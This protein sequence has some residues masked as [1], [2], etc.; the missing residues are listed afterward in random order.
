MTPLQPLAQSSPS[1]SG[2]TVEL[3]TLSLVLMAIVVVGLV[4]VTQVKKRMQAADSGDD[5][6]GFM[7]S[8]LRRLHRNGEMS[9]EE[10]AKARDRV[11]AAAKRAAERDKPAG[12]AGL[13]IGRTRADRAAA[14]ADDDADEDE[15]ADE[16]ETGPAGGAGDGRR[17]DDGSSEPGP[18]VP[19]E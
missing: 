5:G 6:G 3:V 19:R 14:A 18:R 12:T 16:P 11:I 4:I 7:L 15:V 17:D 9:D 2:P 13:D 8:D 10:F 1:G